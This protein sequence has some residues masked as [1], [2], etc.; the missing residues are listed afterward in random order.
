MQSAYG[1]YC[2]DLTAAAASWNELL[3]SDLPAL[4]GMLAKDQLS[5]LPATPITLPMTCP[6]GGPVLA[7][8]K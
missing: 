2:R 1:E 6:A 3:T 5:A 7:S 8:G 4:N